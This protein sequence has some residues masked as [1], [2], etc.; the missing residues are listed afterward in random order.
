MALPD[1]LLSSL[2][3]PLFRVSFVMSVTIG[4]LLFVLETSAGQWRFALLLQ[5]MIGTMLWYLGL[6]S[7]NNAVAL[8]VVAFVAAVVVIQM[9]AINGI[10]E[11]TRR[12]ESG[13]V[14]AQLPLELRRSSRVRPV[15][16]SGRL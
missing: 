10:D 5:P 15:H 9:I 2:S 6:L 8:D 3:N 11:Q 4:T 1:I 13:L 12:F 14:Y 7:F 16:V